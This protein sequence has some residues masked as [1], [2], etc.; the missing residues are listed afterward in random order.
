MKKPL[1]LIALAVCLAI[2]VTSFSSAH[3]PAVAVDSAAM[4]AAVIAWRDALGPELTKKATFTFEGPERTDWHFIPK[5]RVGVKWDDMNLEQRRAAH[6]LLRTALS[7]QG[8]FKALTIMSL[9]QELRRMEAD[10]PDV[11]QIRNPEKYWFALFGDPSSKDPWGW[12][13]EGH[14]LSL[15]FSSVTGQ[16][17]SVTPAFFG[18]NPAELRSGPR[19]GLRVLGAEEDLGRELITS[20]SPEQLKTAVI[21]ETAPGD[22]IALPGLEIKFG[23]PEGLSAEEMTDDQQSLLRKLLEELIGN[24]EGELKDKTFHELEHAGFDKLYFAWAGSLDVGKGHYFRI[25]GPTLVIE[26]DNTQNDANHAH[27]VWH[28]PGNNFGA[29]FLRRHYAES[30]HHQHAK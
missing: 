5:E 4:R 18:T 23:E 21:D 7:S 24:F 27:L 22:V 9:E 14:H 2:C 26:Y 15:N 1:S 10:R 19:T 16:V 6:S 11:E 28:S 17:V 30:P 25:H 12:R 29:D 8:F 13:V 3:E 20:C